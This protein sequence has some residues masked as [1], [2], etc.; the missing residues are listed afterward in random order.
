MDRTRILGR[1]FL[2][3]TMVIVEYYVRRKDLFRGEDVEAVRTFRIGKRRRRSRKRRRRKKVKRKR[4][5]KKEGKFKG[6]KAGKKTKNG[7]VNF[8]NMKQP[9]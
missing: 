7:F 3:F 5:I 2:F 6:R 1:N 9:F 4:K 8:S